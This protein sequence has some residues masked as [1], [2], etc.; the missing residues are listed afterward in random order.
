[1]LEVFGNFVGWFGTITVLGTYG[2]TL[3]GVLK[4]GSD[5]FLIAN[6]AGSITLVIG[7]AFK[8]DMWHNVV[9]YLIW[10]VLT[11]LVYFDVFSL[12]LHK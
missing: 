4:F 9:F 10:G 5:P 6:L 8:R 1:M 11:A 7:G 2:L 3:F 12:F